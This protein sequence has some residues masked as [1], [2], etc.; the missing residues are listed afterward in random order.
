MLRQFGGKV[1]WRALVARAQGVLE[2]G[3]LVPERV[4]EFRL[5]LDKDA[6]APIR[7]E[8]PLVRVHNDG[9]GFVDPAQNLLALLAQDE[10]RAVRAVEVEPEPA[11]SR[12]VAQVA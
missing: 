1:R 5:L 9:V 12:D 3:R 8:E 7:E 4:V 2:V 11:P 10:K 6:S